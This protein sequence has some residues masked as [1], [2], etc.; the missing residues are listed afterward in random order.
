MM[1]VPPA[2]SGAI[3]HSGIFRCTTS[4]NVAGFPLLM[5]ARTKY[6]YRRS[7]AMRW[8]SSS[9][10]R[11]QTNINKGHEHTPEVSDRLS[12]AR[13]ARTLFG[14]CI[15][16]SKLDQLSLCH[17]KFALSFV[18][19]LFEARAATLKFFGKTAKRD[20]FHVCISQELGTF[21]DYFPLLVT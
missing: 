8:S 4:L 1:H 11:Q 3:S 9:K 6:V 14:S 5:R 15:P 10:Q 16:L 7:D 19:N 2:A 18:M 17:F 12:R 20:V 21:S 13:R